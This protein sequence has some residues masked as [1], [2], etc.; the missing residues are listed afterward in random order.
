MNDKTI[1]VIIPCYNE[2]LTIASVVADCRKAMPGATVF[3]Y[4]NNSTDCTAEEAR[5]AGA[6][7]RTEC[8]Q[9]KGYVMR[10]AFRDV[11]ADCYFM[12]DGDATYAL[13]RAAEMCEMVT[14]GRAD[15]VIG[16]RLSTSYYTENKRPFHN[17]G[18]NLV[19]RLV[20]TLFGSDIRD[21]MT[22]MRAMSRSFVVNCPVMR[23]GFELE[24]EMTVCALEKHFRIAQVPVQYS[25]RQEGSVSKLSTFSDGYRV[26]ATIVRL[27]R[28]H[29]P[30]SFFSLLA[31][32]V[33]VPAV[34]LFVPVLTEYLETGLVP[35][36]PTLIV[37][38]FMALVAILLFFCGMI[39][40]VIASRH[41][42]LGEMLI[43]SN[44][45]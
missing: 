19:R 2:E 16:D 42:Q 20:N 31:L 15:V 37:C 4:D 34:V 29:R 3:V 24:T 21:I 6:V 30:L 13:D 18:N 23:G 35:R 25:D 32:V 36:F 27:Y 38:G 28:D 39:L 9:G 12:V 14:S 40:D 7:V 43:I 41:R 44:R 45:M 33:A 22:G 1:A 5:R 8:R 11:V 26:L 10:Q 17:F